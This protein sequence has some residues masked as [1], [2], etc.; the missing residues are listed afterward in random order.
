MPAKHP[1][2]GKGVWGS[3]ALLGISLLL[4]GVIGEGLLRLLGY[5]GEPQSI[6]ANIYPV[7]DAVVDWRYQPNSKVLIGKVTLQYNSQGFRDKE[8]SASKPAGTRRILVLGDSV[9]MGHGVEWPFL[10]SQ[11]VQSRLPSN[12]EVITIAMSGLNT[13]Q[14]VH[15]LE[16]VGVTYDVDMVILNFVLNDADFATVYEASRRVIDDADSTIGLFNIRVSPELKRFLKSS[17]LVY[18]MK[19]RIENMKGKLLGHEDTDYFTRVWQSAGNRRKIVESFERLGRLQQRYGFQT[20]VLIWP[21][22]MDYDRYRFKS[23]H[24]WVGEQ[25]QRNGFTVIDLLPNFSKHSYR[26]LQL[27]AEDNI[28]PNSAGHAIGAEAFLSWYGPSGK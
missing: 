23:I 17:A 7:D 11:V 12:Q 18:F 2:V 13:P 26:D 14:E 3:I 10:F 4:S 15:L 24:Q 22:L 19:D 8:H 16:Q 9:T 5:R 1:S 25:G 21:I 20:V 6:M 27:T 28:H